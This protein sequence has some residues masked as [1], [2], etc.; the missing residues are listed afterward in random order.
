MEDLPYKEES[1]NLEVDQTLFLYTDGVTEAMSP[2]NELFNQVLVTV[3]ASLIL[4]GWTI[5]L[6]GRVMG[7][8][9]KP[10]VAANW[11]PDRAHLD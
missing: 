6:A 3:I 10:G 2:D 1:V 5:P 9:I 7:V 11:P 8:E 4:Q